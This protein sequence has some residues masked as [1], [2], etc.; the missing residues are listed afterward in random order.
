MNESKLS[1]FD[2]K[3]KGILNVPPEKDKNKI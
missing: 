3:L 2:K 1:S